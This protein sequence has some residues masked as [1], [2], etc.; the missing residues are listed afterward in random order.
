MGENSICLAK[1]SAKR[2]GAVRTSSLVVDFAPPVSSSPAIAA[3][4]AFVKVI[5]A[6]AQLYGLVLGISKDSSPA[7][8]K[9]AY[10][11]LLLKIYLDKGSKQKMFARPPTQNIRFLRRGLAPQKVHWAKVQFVL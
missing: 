10:R 11:K 3:T 8:V 9:V 1:H 2:T 7:E 4:R 5:L 6:L